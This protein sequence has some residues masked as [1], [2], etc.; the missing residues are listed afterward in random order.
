MS[1]KDVVDVHFST[2][3]TPPPDLPEDEKDNKEKIPGGDVPATWICPAS[4]KP[5]LQESAGA[6]FVCL[7]PCGHV[8]ADS[9]LRELRGDTTTTDN[10][11]ETS[12]FVCGAAVDPALGV[13]TLNP[14]AAADV[15]AAEA[16]RATLAARGLTHSLKPLK[17]SKSKKKE[18]KKR[19][20]DSGKDVA[21]SHK[22]K[23]KVE[24]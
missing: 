14:A 22:K 8:L 4:Q 6:K 19:S 20:A 5:V 3:S 2:A 21:A 23:Q 11:A 18:S 1:L 17:K 7:V 10:N 24:T 9:A 12:C 15:A 16:R 13:V